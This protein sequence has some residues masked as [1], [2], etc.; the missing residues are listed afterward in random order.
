MAKVGMMLTY[1]GF[2]EAVAEMALLSEPTLHDLALRVAAADHDGDKAAAF[3]VLA[4][5]TTCPISC[6][7]YGSTPTSRHRRWREP[8]GPAPQPWCASTAAVKRVRRT[9]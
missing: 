5:V 9:M 6:P 7:S 8:A 2:A 3:F 1:P 4:R